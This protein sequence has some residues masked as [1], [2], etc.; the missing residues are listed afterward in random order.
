[1]RQGRGFTRGAVMYND[2]V[3][4]GPPGDRARVANAG[5]IVPALR[6]IARAQSAFASRANGSG[7]NAKELT[8]WKQAG[9][10]PS[11]SWYNKPA[12]GWGATLTIA[13]Q[14]RAYT[15][16]DRGTFLATKNLD[17]KILVQGGN[18]LRNPYHVTVVRH[19]GTNVGCARAFSRWITSAPPQ[20]LIG[21][22]GKRQVRTG[23]LSPRRPLTVKLSTATLLWE[24]VAR[25][26]TVS[27]S[28]TAIAMLIGV[29]V[30]TALGLLRLRGQRAAGATVNTGMALPTVVVGLVVRSCSFAAGRSARWTSSTRCG[31]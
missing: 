17:S 9:I 3:L 21:T 6:A 15:L 4:V 14:K 23:A 26:A 29:P 8:L 2:C 12:R 22:F 24:L 20:R 5:G 16:A 7:T 28:A 27:L 13:S 1:M 11:G 10:A 25:T 31:A 18:A 30:G 19:A